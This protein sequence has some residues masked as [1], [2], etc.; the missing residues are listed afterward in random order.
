MVSGAHRDALGV[1]C[2]ADLKGFMARQHERQHAGL[3]LGR[4]DDAHPVDIGKTRCGVLEERM[5]IR[6][7]TFDTNMFHV[8]QCLTQ[9]HRVG[10]DANSRLTPVALAVP[11]PLVVDFAIY[12]QASQASVG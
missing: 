9:A 10:D 8:P 3:L 11:S 5:L 6:R 7:N 1:Q 4:A 12:V 2:L